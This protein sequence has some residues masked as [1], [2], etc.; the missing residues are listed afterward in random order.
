MV[1]ART[2]RSMSF[3]RRVDVARASSSARVFI[4]LDAD[5]ASA[6]S[7]HRC[8]CKRSSDDRCAVVVK[9]SGEVCCCCCCRCRCS[10]FAALLLF[11]TRAPP[12]FPTSSSPE[13]PKTRLRSTEG[14]SIQSEVGVELKGVRRS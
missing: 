14:R 13:P 8:G 12:C 10:L 5:R 6:A 4:A 11:R 2:T 7:R 9:R 1:N 3:A